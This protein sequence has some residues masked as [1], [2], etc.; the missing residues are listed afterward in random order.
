MYCWLS[1]YLE[2][3][4]KF[5]GGLGLIRGLGLLPT[6]FKYRAKMVNHNFK[7]C[8][9]VICHMFDQS[10]IDNIFLYSDSIMY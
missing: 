8:I 4:F 6:P 3:E 5:I 7:F 2:N 9:I 1:L 10:C